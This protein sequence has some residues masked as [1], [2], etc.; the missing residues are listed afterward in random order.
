MVG[1]GG[2]MLMC[3]A[4]MPMSRG[5]MRSRC[6]KPQA[7]KKKCKGAPMMMQKECYAAPE[8]PSAFAMN[9]AM[10]DSSMDGNFDM[11]M[12]STTSKKRMGKK[13]KKERK[14]S[15]SSVAVSAEYEMIMNAQ[16]FDGF[17]KTS[18]ISAFNLQ[19]VLNAS[20]DV[21]TD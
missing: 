7:L 16:D 6:A 17:F 11:A 4:A 14:S 9:N 12:Q 20:N 15:L 13:D 18:F 1:F 2:P 5:G 8:M 3:K 21:I 10:T 19:D